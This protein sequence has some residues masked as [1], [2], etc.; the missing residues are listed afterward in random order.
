MPV[1]LEN[2]FKSRIEVDEPGLVYIEGK[3]DLADGFGEGT[4]K[5]VGGS[6]ELHGRKRNVVIPWAAPV[7]GQD[8]GH[9]H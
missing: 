5:S 3:N 8:A 6:I 9:D 1:L 2:R 7:W 4:Q